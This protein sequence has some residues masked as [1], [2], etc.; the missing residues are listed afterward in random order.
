MTPKKIRT[1][2]Q[3]RDW[4]AHRNMTRE[5]AASEF[6]LSLRTLKRY[7]APDRAAPL[8]LTFTMALW[9]YDNGFNTVRR[10]RR[11]SQNAKAAV[12]S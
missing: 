7:T 12:S 3:F 1:P 5:G 4:L 6:G 2:Q 9:A 8:P 11:A 10:R